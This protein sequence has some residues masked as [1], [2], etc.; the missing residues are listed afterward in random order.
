MQIG[1]KEILPVGDRV[2]IKPDNP[3]ERTK[4]GLYLPQTV[5]EK[6]PVWSGRVLATGPGIPI[7][8]LSLDYREPW[9]ES[10]EP[11]ARFIPVQAEV[12]DYALFLRKEAVEVVFQGEKFLVVPQSGILLLIRA[13]GEDVSQALP[14]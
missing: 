12:G 2:L 6:E 10:R 11:Q 8:S 4:V 9:Q 3:D 5:V 13:E 7:P 1:N 14:P